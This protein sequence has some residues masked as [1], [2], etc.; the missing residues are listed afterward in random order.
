MNRLKV[1]KLLC[2]IPLAVVLLLGSWSCGFRK[3]KIGVLYVLHGG[4]ETNNSQG[5]WDAVVQQFS[6]EHNHPIYHFCYLG[7]CPVAS[8]FGSYS[9]RFCKA[10]SDNV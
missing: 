2:I 5:M 6:Y 1:N 10:V 7:S 9:N 3:E 4:M 8:C